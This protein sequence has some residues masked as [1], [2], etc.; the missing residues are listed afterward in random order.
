[1]S[2]ISHKV[3]KVMIYGTVAVMGVNQVALHLGKKLSNDEGILWNNK[4]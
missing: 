1:M 4:Y 2:V 3:F